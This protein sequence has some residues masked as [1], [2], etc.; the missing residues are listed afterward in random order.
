MKGTKMTKRTYKLSAIALVLLLGTAAS[1][2]TAIHVAKTRGCGCC[3]AWMDRLT[4][5]E[6][7]PEGQNIGG[8]LIRLKMDRGIPVQMFS[9]HTA[10]VEGYTIEG[11]VPPADIVRLL[12]ERPDAIGL[13]VP[14]MP[15]GSPGMDFGDDADAY[16]VFIVNSDGTTE[17]F[18]SYSGN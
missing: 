2:Q 15:L 16:D 5:A 6:F 11:H 7:T 1:A 10:T 13:A 3:L 17:V 9:C 14:G 18:S 12:E 8:A 4:K